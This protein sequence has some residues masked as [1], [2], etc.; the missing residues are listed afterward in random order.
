MNNKHVK[1]TLF[2]NLYADFFQWYQLTSPIW[3]HTAK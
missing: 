3:A 2:G 1:A